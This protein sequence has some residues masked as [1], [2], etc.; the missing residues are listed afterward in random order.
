MPHF[1][2]WTPGSEWTRR[3]R[4]IYLSRSSPRKLRDEALALVWPRLMELFVRAEAPSGFTA[5]WEQAPRREFFF[6]WQNRKARR[7][8]RKKR[9]PR[10]HW[11]GAKPFCW[12]KMKHAFEN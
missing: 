6:P 4:A 9:L 7:E 8:L 5:S 10:K 11:K 2:S 3:R 12:W 1:R